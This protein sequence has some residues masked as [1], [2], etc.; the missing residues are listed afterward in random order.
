MDQERKPQQMVSDILKRLEVDI[1]A[2]INSD[3]MNISF[4]CSELIKE[5]KADISLFGGNKIIAVWCK[6][7]SG[8]TIYTNYDFID[9]DQPIVES[10]LN[11]GEYISEMTMSALLV[12]LEKQNKIL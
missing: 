7:T 4:E 12:L 8:V 6:N 11:E 5:L 2:F 3:G 10:E 9:K 1:M